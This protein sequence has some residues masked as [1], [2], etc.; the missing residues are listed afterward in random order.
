MTEDEAKT[1][2]ARGGRALTVSATAICVMGLAGP[3]LLV[4]GRDPD[5]LYP[6][7]VVGWPLAVG[8]AL[9]WLRGFRARVGRG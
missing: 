4:M 8:G 2:K 6:L 3:V 5:V 9:Y 7:Y 1:V